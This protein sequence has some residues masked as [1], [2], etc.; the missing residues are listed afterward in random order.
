LLCPCQRYPL[1]DIGR[2]LC[3][4]YAIVFMSIPINI[5]VDL[6]VRY[7][8]QVA[9][10][11]FVVLQFSCRPCDIPE[12]HLQVVLTKGKGRSW[13]NYRSPTMWY[14]FTFL[15]SII[16]FVD[17]KKIEPFRLS[18]IHS[19]TTRKVN[20]MHCFSN[21]FDKVPYMFRTGPL[22]IIRSISTLYT[23][24]RYLSCLF[25]WRLIA[26]IVHLVGFHYKNISQ[27]VV[28]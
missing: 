18:P 20:E 10:S 26:E 11:V 24:N 27:C 6:T 19:E 3:E 7:G 1:L 8:H 28:L 5:K 16:L 13:H 12:S 21:L 2:I 15:S 23:R 14:V 4:K 22:P 9:Y 25:C 17:C